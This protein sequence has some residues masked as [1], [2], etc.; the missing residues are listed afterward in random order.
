MGKIVP[1]AR[2]R[3]VR[4]LGQFSE[5]RMFHR[6]DVGA[7][8]RFVEQGLRFTKR[9]ASD[10]EVPTELPVRAAEAFGDVRWR[11]A[12]GAGDLI[13]E[14][15]ISSDAGAGSHCEHRIAKFHGKP[16]AIELSVMLDGGHAAA[17]RTAHAIDLRVPKIL[18]S[19]FPEILATC[20]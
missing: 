7:C 10:K 12:R 16:P 3:R 5:L 4:A 18:T 15:E 14:S 8:A 2:G 9:P 1:E 6:R 11:R 17:E 13:A 20:R 19:S